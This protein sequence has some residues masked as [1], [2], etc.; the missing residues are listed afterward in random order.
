MPLDY[1]KSAICVYTLPI[2]LDKLELKG[3]NRGSFKL[4]RIVLLKLKYILRKE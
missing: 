4:E 3:Y 1:Q 2:T